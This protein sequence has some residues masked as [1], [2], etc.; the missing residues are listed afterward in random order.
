MSIREIAKELNINE[1]NVK[2]YLYR[3]LKELKNVVKQRS[4][5]NV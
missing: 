3:T 2:H 5:E 1:S 4:E